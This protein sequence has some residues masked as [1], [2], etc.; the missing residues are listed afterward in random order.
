VLRHLP[1]KGGRVEL[2]AFGEV[3]IQAFGELPMTYDLLEE[4]TG[5]RAS[6]FST[7]DDYQGMAYL[8]GVH[9]ALGPEFSPDYQYVLTRAW[10]VQ[11]S[12]RLIAHSGDVSLEERTGPLD[13]TVVAGLFLS[14]SQLDENG[15]AWVDGPLTFVAVGGTAKRR[16]WVSLEFQATT[17]VQLAI[18]TGQVTRGSASPTGLLHVCVQATGTAPVRYARVGLEFNAI[19]PAASTDSYPP[20]APPTGVQL[21]SMLVS[22]VG[23]LGG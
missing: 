11:T 23:C 20:P 1:A 8:Q 6:F 14:P 22:D 15:S 19:P 3:P 2:E 18:P 17:A 5:G 13:V 21:T 10:G 16:V 12:R 4:R 9:T 7:L